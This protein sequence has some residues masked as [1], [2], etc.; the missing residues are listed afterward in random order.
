MAV[1]LRTNLTNED[2][3]NIGSNTG[4]LGYVKESPHFFNN[5]DDYSA[6]ESMLFARLFRFKR[7]L[8]PENQEDFDARIERREYDSPLFTEGYGE[9]ELIFLKSLEGNELKYTITANKIK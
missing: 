2:L 4:L 8:H 6:T 3:F 1:E 7:V 5:M 9:Y